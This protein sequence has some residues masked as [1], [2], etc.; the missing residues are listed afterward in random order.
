MAT[1]TTAATI[2]AQLTLNA[3]DFN[4]G[5]EAASDKSTTFAKNFKNVGKSI[6]NVG[7][8]M[9]IA[10][11][12]ITAG[13]TAP[14][15]A[16]VK[17]GGEVAGI[18]SAF[19]SMVE[20]WGKD[21]D[22]FLKHTQEVS[23]GMISNTEIMKNMNLAAALVGD[24]FAQTLPDAMGLLQK[25]A[26][27]TGQSL[28]YM[29]SSYTTGIA[30]ESKMI[31]DN[32]GLSIDLA[33]AKEEYAISIGKTTEQLTAQEQKMALTVA[34]LEGLNKAYGNMPDVPDQTVAIAQMETAWANLKDTLGL[35][36]AEAL[37]PAI[38]GLNE[39]AQDHLPKIQEWLNSMDEETKKNVG[40]MLML[41]MGLG[42]LMLVLSPVVMAIGSLVSAF[43][44]L[45]GLLGAGGGAAGAAAGG[46]GVIAG[47]SALVGVLTSAPVVILGVI[48]ALGLMGVA[49]SEWAE[50]NENVTMHYEETAKRVQEATENN[51]AS[52]Y[53]ANNAWVE[54]YH[55]GN[56]GIQESINSYSG[57]LTAMAN[58]TDAAAGGI[59]GSITGAANATGEA[60][61]GA[62]SAIGGWIGALQE[63]AKGTDATVAGMQAMVSSAK[64]QA[65]S[66]ARWTGLANS[67]A[68]SGG[69]GLRSDQ[70]IVTPYGIAPVSAS[71]NSIA[72]S[73][74]YANR[75]GFGNPFASGGGSAT[76]Y[77]GGGGST[78]SYRGGGG[79]YGSAGTGVDLGGGG[80]GTPDV[81]FAPGAITVTIQGNADDTDIR[82]SV[83][84]G[85]C[86]ALRS[87]GYG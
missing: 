49:L 44:G 9:A 37:T 8:T 84:L 50:N 13:I 16:L 45:A 6:T 40:S 67:Y 20:G 71:S 29:L 74:R 86:D 21:A 87:V 30:R 10:G 22:E 14:T 42:A 23:N 4:K 48:G 75:M 72:M 57:A 70:G 41:T 55:N 68:G 81:Y 32:L 27:A 77:R 3:K 65:A 62:V 80:D 82:N 46:G 1:G 28:D 7:K 66:A 19:N 61:E 36:L 54:A 58:T 18:Q 11:A 63:L 69:A 35:F 85:V 43:S 38:Q 51:T 78:T 39:L 31:L 5:I 76:S 24:E 2:A 52:I 17:L 60:S 53:N 64:A 59:S 56:I 15:V 25:A 83:K 33:A 73:M 12:S 79:G 47:F 26:A 34:T